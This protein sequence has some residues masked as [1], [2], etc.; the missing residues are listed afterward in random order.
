MKD[1]KIHWI[2]WLLYAALFVSVAAF[3]LYK[4]CP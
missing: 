1:E 3:G 4:L 2:D